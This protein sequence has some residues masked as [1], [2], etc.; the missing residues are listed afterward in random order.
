MN[1]MN[2]SANNKT[3]FP[4]SALI[5]PALIFVAFLSAC[6]GRSSTVITKTPETPT[7]AMSPTVT[8]PAPPIP[9]ESAPQGAEQEFST[10]FTISSI[11]F[12]EILSGGPPKDG[13]PALNN[14]RFLEVEEVGD[15]IGDLEPV[16]VF[17]NQGDIRIY[18]LQILIWHEIVNDVVGDMPVAITFCPLCN[19]AIAFDATINGMVLDFGTTGRLRYSNLVMYDRQTETW[20]QQAT[21]I[22]IVGQL[23][24]SQLTFLPTSI[25]GW[26]QARQTYPDA[27]VLSR[28]TGYN[29]NY[30]RN[31][32]P[33]YD[34]VNSSPFLYDGPPT[35]GELPA[36]ARITTVDINNDAVAYPNDTVQSLRVINDTVGGKDI[37]IFSEEGLASAL[38]ASEIASG[39]DV[40]ATGVFERTLDG[41]TLTFVLSENKIIDEQSGSV[42]NIFGQAISGDLSGQ[43]LIT[44]VKV[45]HF[46]FSW[47]AFRPDT[48]IYQP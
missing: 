27:L 33:G 48:R 38:D 36:M 44:V 25:I 4:K 39:E 18:P 47:V 20:W 12:D 40:G 15:W 13:I 1:I 34:N 28:E 9:Q 45:D 24:G 22:A 7:T 46:W 41:Q 8:V 43:S 19:T 37:V 3:V 11:S 14:P 42:W 30:G 26:S 5:T 23:T 35:P 2:N 10:D 16:I 32:Y 31:P 17:E 21:G 6:S 29:R